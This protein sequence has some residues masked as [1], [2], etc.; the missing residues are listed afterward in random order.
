M[1]QISNVLGSGVGGANVQ[2]GGSVQALRPSTGHAHTWGHVSPRG[3]LLLHVLT[4]NGPAGLGR[5]PETTRQRFPPHAPG[6]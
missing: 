1:V 2:P 5:G 3:S 6:L 4:P